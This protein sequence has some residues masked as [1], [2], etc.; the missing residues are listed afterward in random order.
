MKEISYTELNINPMTLIGGEWMLLT[1]GTREHGYNTMTCSWGH[2]GAI[3]GHGG[4]YPT[5]V[6]YVRPQRYTKEF[7]DREELYT[8]CFFNERK[9]ELAYLGTHS[10]RDE[11]K[12]AKVGF[13]PAFGEGYT[14][15]EEAKLVLVCRK[16]YRAPLKEEGFF[17]PEVVEDNYPNRDF[18]DLYIGKI[19]KVLV[20]D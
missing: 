13:T 9:K 2:L 18:H 1:A 15:F 6:C 16:L 17:H 7:V 12:V 20:A 10:G 19:E 14:Y 5:S 4:G 11:D 8:L 3:W